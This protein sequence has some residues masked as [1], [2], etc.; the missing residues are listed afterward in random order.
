[1]LYIRWIDCSSVAVLLQQEE[2][3]VT[4]ETCDAFFLLPFLF[5]NACLLVPRLKRLAANRLDYSG[6]RL[7]NCNKANY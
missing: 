7:C 5:S 2:T 1:M 4:G 3:R 6:T